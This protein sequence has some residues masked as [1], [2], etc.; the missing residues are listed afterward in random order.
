ML[1]ENIVAMLDKKNGV[2]TVLELDDMPDWFILGA[3]NNRFIDA[4]RLRYELG[5]LVEGEKSQVSLSVLVYAFEFEAIERGSTEDMKQLLDANMNLPVQGRDFLT[6]IEEY[7]IKFV[8]VDTQ[9]V[10]SNI[11]AT[12]AL[13]KIYDNGRT[14]VY[15]TKR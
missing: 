15:T 14:T 2:L 12:P 6:Y 1:N 7:N 8:A 10:V 11:E 13:D 3:L 5:D 4:L 9:K